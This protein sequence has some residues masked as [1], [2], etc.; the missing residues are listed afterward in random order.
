MTKTLTYSEFI[1]YAKKYY[2]KGGDGYLSA[3]VSV[4]L[5]SM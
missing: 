4:N 2:E 5:M 3:G 1:E